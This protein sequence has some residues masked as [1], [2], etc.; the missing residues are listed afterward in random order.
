MSQRPRLT[1][2]YWEGTTAADFT[3][4]GV[5]QRCQQIG[6]VLQAQR[7]R[8]LVTHDTRFMAGHFA[9]YAYQVLQAQGVT[10]AMFSPPAPF[11]AVE[12]AL[13]QRRADAALLLSARNLPFWYS[14]MVLM[15]PP[16][17]QPLLAP[18]A[19]ATPRDPAIGFPLPPFDTGDPVQLDLRAPYLEALRSAIDVDLIRRATLTVFVDPMN[20]TTS[21]Y[22]PAALGDNGQTKAIEINREVD[23]LFG[24]QPPQPTEAGLQRL[25]KLV[26]ESDSHLGVALSADGRAL[27][28]A[29]NTGDLVTPHDLALLLADYL[30][31]EYRQR[32]TVVVPPIAEGMD[33]SALRS[34]ESAAG[35][36]VEF[37]ADPAQRI[38]DL[39]AGDRNSL[40]V[41]VTPNGEVTLGRYGASPD[42]VLV[43]LLLIEI[44]ARF[45][46]R[47][48][49]LLDQ[50]RGKQ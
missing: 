38:A 39:L 11:P 18:P 40:L 10:T 32:G 22:I 1:R 15:T 25:R 46:S 41:G 21:G 8:C 44:A 31:R 12:L 19:I 24:R 36:K 7:W 37:A 13:D 16:L 20:G 9:R 6:Q 47:L 50:V 3:L 28:A 4:D 35:L 48:R 45:G 30:H 26:K 14:G 34:W 29:D 2:Q 42:A 27:A 23:P 43:S 5:Y 33:V 17:D 49:T